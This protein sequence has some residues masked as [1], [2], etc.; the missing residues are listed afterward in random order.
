MCILLKYFNKTVYRVIK[1]EKFKISAA[2]MYAYYNNNNYYSY[3]YL[4]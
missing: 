2:Y 4:F 3:T 1:Y